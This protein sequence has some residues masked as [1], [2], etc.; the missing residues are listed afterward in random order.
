M[1][2]QK[3]ALSIATQS[4][5][6]RESSLVGH[7]WSGPTEGNVHFRQSRLGSTQSGETGNGE[8]YRNDM[9]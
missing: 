8:A 1:S 5:G 4:W 7:S 6:D 9:V 3:H 2:L